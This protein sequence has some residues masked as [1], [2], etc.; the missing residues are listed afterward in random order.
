MSKIRRI[1]AVPVNITD[2]FGRSSH[3]IEVI[4]RFFGITT[5]K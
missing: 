2:A 1:A 3:E 4:R 5:D